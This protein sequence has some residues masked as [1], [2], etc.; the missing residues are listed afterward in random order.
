MNECER[1]REVVCKER[2][3]GRVQGK[4]LMRSHVPFFYSILYAA[5]HQTRFLLRLRPRSTA[6]ALLDAGAVGPMRARRLS[7]MVES[8]TVVV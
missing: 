8:C 5:T 1:E 6:A 4:S 7:S 3:R 2:E